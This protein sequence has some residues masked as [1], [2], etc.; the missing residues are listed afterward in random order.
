MSDD[1]RE[2]GADQH[3]IDQAIGLEDM[4]WGAIRLFR[5]GLRFVGDFAD[6]V[7]DQPAVAGSYPLVLGD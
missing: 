7:E 1:L 3:L 2:A 5:T 6:R 4:V